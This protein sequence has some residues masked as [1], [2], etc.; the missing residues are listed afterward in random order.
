MIP[1]KGTISGKWVGDGKQVELHAVRNV[2]FRVTR[3]LS[4]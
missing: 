3:R 1:G 4:K 2:N